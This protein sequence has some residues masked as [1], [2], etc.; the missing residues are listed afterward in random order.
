MRQHPGSVEDSV[1]TVQKKKKGITSFY[2]NGVKQEQSYKI[3][4][5]LASN[6]FY[7]MI[8]IIEE[9]IAPI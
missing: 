2:T 8:T 3:K 9:T 1:F 4:Q 7:K 5:L 6:V